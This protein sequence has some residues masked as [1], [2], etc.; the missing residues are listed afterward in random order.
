MKKT[1]TLLKRFLTVLFLISSISVKAQFVTI[2]DPNF[3]TYLTTMFPSCMSGNQMDTTCGPITWQNTVNVAGLGITDMTGIQY[4][5]GLLY[6]DCSNNSLTG[7]PILP[8]SVISINCSYNSISGLPALPPGLINLTTNNNNLSTLPALPSTV[9]QIYA[10]TNSINT[11]PVLSPGLTL[12]H[13]QSNNLSTLPTLPNTITYLLLGFNN[14]TSL[15]ALPTGLQQLGVSS[16]SLTT[17]P[18]LPAPMYFLDCTN[19][20]LTSLPTLPGGLVQLH[21]Y[22]NA[23]TNLPNLP[24]TLQQLSV[25]GNPISCLPPLPNSIFFLYILGSGITC[26]PNYPTNVTSFDTDPYT[27]PL[28]Q[29][30]SGCPIG[31]NIFGKNYFDANTNC[32]Y[33]MG[34]NIIGYIPV[35]LY[36]SGILVQQSFSPSGYFGFNT[37]SLGNYDV[38]VDTAGLPFDFACSTPGIDTNITLTALDSIA[39][40]IDFGYKCK[41]GYD[42]A[43]NSVNRIAGIFFPGEGVAV[44][45][46]AGD[47]ATIY[48]S[49][50]TCNT[51]GISGTVQ[52]TVTGPVTYV[53]PIGGAL[54]P[55]VAGN[56]FTYN[57]A[58]FSLLN[59]NTDFGLFFTTDVTATSADQVCFDVAV[60]SSG[61][62]NNLANNTLNHCFNVVNSLDPNVKEVSPVGDLDYPFSD[63][64]TYTIHFQNTGSAPA[65][66]I[67]VAD[68][69]DTDLDPS[70]FRLLNS[71][72]PVQ[73]DMLGSNIQFRFNGIML[74]DSAT[75][76]P[77]S[78]GWVQYKIKADAGLLAG[79]VINNTADIYFDFNSPVTTNTTLNN[80]VAPFGIE[81]N[82]D[83][84]V[85]MY[86]NPAS[87]FLII[88]TNQL[89]TN[90]SV[91]IIDMLGRTMKQIILTDMN[92]MISLEGFVN[93]MY[94]VKVVD[95]SKEIVKKIIIQK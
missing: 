14:F 94:S 9:T 51:S 24:N 91:Q 66:N 72:H 42:V 78:H 49:N 29:L 60:S 34:E 11:L 8:A 71:S 47:L 4:F 19:N 22:G 16:N 21:A 74:T 67:R 68:V 52:I 35:E 59:V 76:E 77:A 18:A 55:S 31:Y 54:T 95:G 1:P 83:L 12:L 37:T 25:A 87:D 15:P 36:Q 65:I 20:N 85:T 61:T 62:E 7:L 26:L 28:C 57:I 33:Q 56:V 73:V 23:L 41:P 3:V 6:F 80:V 88:Q 38:V 70:T 13:L 93:G 45:I 79:A 32:S 81:S 44:R 63:W 50:L 46:H 10:S 48:N 84:S 64:L 5:D 40:D 82:Q 86:P 39:E 30:S 58:D 27:L 17:L 75:N 90:A 53:A 92:Q 43:A 2:P 69:L 89:S